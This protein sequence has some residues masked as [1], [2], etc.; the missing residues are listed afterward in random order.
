MLAGIDRPPSDRKLRLFACGCCRISPGNRSDHPDVAACLRAAEALADGADYVTETAALRK[1][2]LRKRILPDFFAALIARDAAEAAAKWAKA[3]YWDCPARDAQASLLRDIVGNPWRPVRLGAAETCGRCDG[4]GWWR[5]R[6]LDGPFVAESIYGG[7]S[8]H[9]CRDCGGTGTVPGRP[10]SWL[11]DTA[12][13]LARAAYEDRLP[14]GL[15]DPG[16]LAIL[17]D[18]LEEAGCDEAALLGHLRG[19]DEC[20][21]CEVEIPTNKGGRATV[22][23]AGARLSIGGESEKVCLPGCVHCNRTG[24]R[25]PGPHVRGCGALDL[26]LG[27]E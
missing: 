6:S 16:R 27:E 26:I 24:R 7:P 13:Q 21:V 23:L 9:A 1:R 3:T 18:C 19:E 11:T 10:P 25:K 15:L 20:A 12:R 14:D 2:I 8:T 17:A 4:K 22:Q 5:S